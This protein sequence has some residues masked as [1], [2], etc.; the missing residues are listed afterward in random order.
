MTNFFLYRIRLLSCIFKEN[1]Q[2]IVYCMYI[3]QRSHK[4]LCNV[5]FMVSFYF[6]EKNFLFKYEMFINCLLK[7][8]SLSLHGMVAKK[9]VTQ[10]K[11]N[12]DVICSLL[13]KVYNLALRVHRVFILS[14]D[15]WG[16]EMAPHD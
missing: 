5:Q 13:G 1:V 10:D 2:N 6:I 9:L 16:R 7:F 15:T 3:S 11:Q 4:L 12:S 14:S 8:P